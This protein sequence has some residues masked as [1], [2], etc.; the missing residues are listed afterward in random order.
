MRT[1]T[2]NDTVT[3]L[4]PDWQGTTHH[5]VAN[6]T[7]DLK[8][9]WQDPYGNT[10]G[11]PPTGWTGERSFVGGT[12]D[13]TGLIRIGARDYDPVLQRFVT[14]DPVQ[15]LADPLQWNPYLYA[16]NTP[17]TK[18]D[19]TGKAVCIDSCDWDRRRYTTAY[20]NQEAK[21]LTGHWL[22]RRVAPVSTRHRGPIALTKA[23]TRTRSMG[24][25]PPP[26]A[27]TEPPS[28][29]PTNGG[30]TTSSWLDRQ[31]LPSYHGIPDAPDWL[32]PA[33]SSTSEVSAW[34]GLAA[35]LIA[36][37]AGVA[38]LVDGPG[39][40]VTGPIAAIAARVGFIAGVT[41][42]G[43]DVV[44]MAVTG[45][46][47][48]RRIGLDALGFVSGGASRSVEKAIAGVG[49][50]GRE[51]QYAP[52]VVGAVYSVGLDIVGLGGR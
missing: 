18:A 40:A 16:S 23:S 4:I 6:A 27:P 36:G 10:R 37:V 26:S 28:T 22:P 34:L 21:R 48:P 13:A 29:P 42:A 5:Q 49:M 33:L 2:S 50:V 46:I 31:L 43:A 12:K 47:T 32:H 14:V 8:T 41:S 24:P 1:G 51:L 3:T 44:D 9:T 20:R 19:P 52:L 7:G 15:D 35:D 45:D 25:P 30:K 38:T 11:V 17:I 39:A